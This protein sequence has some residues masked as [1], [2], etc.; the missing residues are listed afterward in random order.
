MEKKIKQRALNTEKKQNTIF[1]LN[2]RF[3]FS[4]FSDWTCHDGIF[5]IVR[6]DMNNKYH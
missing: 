5:V 3:L 1:V 6:N 2:K 4:S